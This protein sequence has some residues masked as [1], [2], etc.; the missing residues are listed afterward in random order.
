M[1]TNQYVKIFTLLSAKFLALLDLMRQTNTQSGP[2]QRRNI[3][4]TTVRAGSGVGVEGEKLVSYGG[5]FQF[6]PTAMQ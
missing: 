1:L 2:S 4:P 3:I 6:L 5:I